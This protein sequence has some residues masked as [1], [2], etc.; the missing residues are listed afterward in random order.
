MALV[1]DRRT[2]SRYKVSGYK[3]G[4]WD[5]AALKLPWPLAE[6]SQQADKLPATLA[7]THWRTCPGVNIGLVD[8]TFDGQYTGA[9]GA[10]GAAT[11]CHV[12]TSAMPS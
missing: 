6:F 8:W 2:A 3:R 1:A 12:N 4:E 5:T 7:S 11:E 9:G 10:R